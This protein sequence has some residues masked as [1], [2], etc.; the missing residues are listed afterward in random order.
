MKK[1]FRIWFYLFKMSWMEGLEYRLNFI[2][3]V[4]TEMLWYAAQLIVFEVLFVH[5]SSIGQWD[6]HSIRIFMG[7]LFMMDVVWMIFFNENFDRFSQLVTKGELDLLLVKP[8]D[9]QFMVSLRKMNPVYFLNFILVF[10]YFMWAIVKYPHPIGAVAVVK[11][12]FLL[13]CG[14]A[15][16]YSLRFFF[17]ILNLL[18]HNANSLTYVWYNFYRFA[19]RPHNIY[20]NWLR[21][22]LVSFLP[23]GMIISVPAYNLLFPSDM[24]LWTSPLIAV[25]LL[26]ACRRA[27]FWALSKYSSASS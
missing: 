10:S 8:V 4:I 5:T 17:A 21:V 9:S 24:T 7:T 19:T 27:W 12:L 25:A 20:P 3:R 13:L 18:I 14:L 22:A 1:H 15:V 23:I 26:W 2:L 16:L 11:Y 6:I